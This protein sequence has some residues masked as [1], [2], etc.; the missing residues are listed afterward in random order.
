M[1]RYATVTPT[2]RSR[3]STSVGAKMAL[4]AHHLWGDDPFV[5]DIDPSGF[6]RLTELGVT[7]VTADLARDELPYLAAFDAVFLCEVIEHL[8]IPGH[9]ALARLR[10]TLRS[11]G[12]LLCT[13]PN[14]YRLRNLAYLAMG[15]PLFDHFDLPGSGG[16]GHVLEYSAEH[17]VLAVR[18]RRL[19]RLRGR[20]VRHP[21]HAGAPHGSCAFSGSARRCTASPLSR[22]ARGHRHRAVTLP[23]PFVVVDDVGSVACITSRCPP[24]RA[25]RTATVEPHALAAR[26][27]TPR[28]ST[29]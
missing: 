1:R 16:C 10:R 4:L 8:P 3:C 21:A 2:T 27:R 18:A 15:R 25:A 26:S 13:T 28:R 11:D 6:E 29:R 20:A 17:P 12:V 23:A 19:P 5:V 7:A 24:S 9:V 22:L 14:L